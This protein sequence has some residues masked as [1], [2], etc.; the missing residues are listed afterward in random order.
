[1]TGTLTE[2][3]PFDQRYGL[4]CSSFHSQNFRLNSVSVKRSRLGQ[5]I[6][7]GW[8][9]IFMISKYSPWLQENKRT[10]LFLC[11]LSSNVRMQTREELSIGA[12]F[13]F[14]CHQ[15]LSMVRLSINKMPW[16]NVQQLL[17]ETG[18]YLSAGLSW[19][20]QGRE[21]SNR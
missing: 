6:F 5:A 15:S 14:V 9:T 10:P 18:S 21:P 20:F 19:Q 8:Q 12:D 17:L 16:T 4:I 3:S 13:G 1:M 2:A 7:P 11:N